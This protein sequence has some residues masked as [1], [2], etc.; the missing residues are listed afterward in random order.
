[1]AN[2]RIAAALRATQPI[3]AKPIRLLDVLV[4]DDDRDMADSLTML[5]RMWG[6]DVRGSYGG[7]QALEMASHRRPDVFLLDVGMPLIN[8][9]ELTRRLRGQP[10]FDRT[11]IIAVSGFV[12]HAH[13]ALCHR[14]GF[15]DFFAKPL[16]LAV[17]KNLL[18]SERHRRTKTVIPGTITSPSDWLSGLYRTDGFSASLGGDSRIKLNPKRPSQLLR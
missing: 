10:W 9:C 8:G 3:Q 4:V 11:R 14:A 7:E 5:L 18:E 13:Q 17:L 2:K 1:M 6:H 15:D 16:E 12:D